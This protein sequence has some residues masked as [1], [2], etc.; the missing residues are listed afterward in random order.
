MQQQTKQTYEFGP[1]RLDPVKRVLLKEDDPVQLTPKA[2]ETLLAL[3]ESRGQLLE[4]DELMQRLWPDSFVE[5]GNL[6][7]NIS[8]LRKAL[9]EHRGEHR[10]IVTVPGRGY[11][12]VADVR[13]I[14]D[15]GGEL[16]VQEYAQARVVIEATE[17]N[18]PALVTT[19]P[20]H[21]AVRA[22]VVRRWKSLLAIVILVSVTLGLLMGGRSFARKD[23]HASSG[24]SP[25][26]KFTPLVTWRSEP[27][28]I[29]TYGRFSHNG[30]FIAFSSLKDGSTDIW[31]KQIMGGAPLRITHDEW[32][33]WG[34]IWSFDDQQIA[35]CSARGGQVGIWSMPAFGG[36][37]VLLTPLNYKVEMPELK[38]WSADATTI[39][40]KSDFNLFALDV[41]TK[42]STP[43]TSFYS[44]RDQPRSLSISPDG[45]QIAYI[46]SQNGQVGIWTSLRDGS[47]ARLI[48]S[49]SADKQ[50]LH[51]HPNGAQLLYTSRLT[52]THQ[53]Y[54]ADLKSNA[55]AQITSDDHDHLGCD[56]SY[57]GSKI[58][59][60]HSKDE[61]DIW[62]V[63]LDSGEEAELTTEIGL[64]FW[65]DISPRQPQMVF[66]SISAHTRFFRSTIWS[67]VL[68]SDSQAVQISSEGFNPSFSPDGTKIAFL[69]LADG[70]VNLWLTPAAGGAETQLTK[71]GIAFSG[72]T[73]LPCN[74]LEAKSFS[75]S[76]DGETLTCCSAQDDVT[77]LWQIS[78]TDLTQTRL[79]NN[80]NPN[81]VLF[82]PL[83]QP[84]GKRIA[85]MATMSSI[86]AGAM[87]ERWTVWVWEEGRSKLVYESPVVCRLIGWSSSGNELIIGSGRGGEDELL[88]ASNVHLFR[89]SVIDGEIKEIADLPSA[90]LLNIQVSSDGQKVAFTARQEGKDNIWILPLAGG[91]GRQLTGNHDPKT[92]YSSLAWSPDGQMIYYSRQE[93]WNVI[94]MIEN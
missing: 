10:Y 77:N 38:S 16:L 51:W 89:L 56:I 54:L 85:Y 60:I 74:R 7:V 82:Y 68:T 20:T 67:K 42:E 27:G 43:L 79:T 17:E 83:H 66:Q 44:L 69:R 22:F 80:S 94:S 71:E 84:N 3:V 58:L 81:D 87:T 92:Y 35:F 24:L 59:D 8:T 40:Y 93:G 61:A 18:D 32:E 15:N 73:Y 25:L 23:P 45:K 47:D 2:F 36:T 48:I 46:E 91:N 78:L 65:P 88:T 9:G 1:F 41:R 57:D 11:C 52:G 50:Q 86:T 4:K 26:A 21:V 33:D 29:N 5:E 76:A 14:L 34:P 90:Y 53:I 62:G 55:I 39:I 64:E 19:P 31:I 28:K 72:Y 37:P 63:R 70:K 6:T 13:E 30:N 12:F 75:W 49:D